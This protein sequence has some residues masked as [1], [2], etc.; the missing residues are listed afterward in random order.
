M[1]YLLDFTIK[2]VTLYSIICKIITFIP[3]CDKAPHTEEN[4]K[5]DWIPTDQNNM[6]FCILW[7]IHLFSDLYDVVDFTEASQSF[8]AML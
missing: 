4:D 5:S 7:D 6:M 1:E 2:P 8:E 3:T